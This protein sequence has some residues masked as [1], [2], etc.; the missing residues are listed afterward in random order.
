MKFLITA[1]KLPLK[2]GIGKFQDLDKW[3]KNLFLWYLRIATIIAM[4]INLQE[5]NYF[6]ALLFFLLFQFVWANILNS[7]YLKA[8]YFKNEVTKPFESPTLKETNQER[9]SDLKE[10]LKN[11]KEIQLQDNQIKVLESELNS[12]LN[13][14]PKLKDISN[15][16]KIEEPKPAPPKPNPIVE[17]NKKDLK[18]ILGKLGF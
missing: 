10:W 4:S 2:L 1:I 14:K 12:L 6:T 16:I 5:Q 9:I 11:T 8:L 15:E 13:S 7:I 3:Y 17:A 18:T